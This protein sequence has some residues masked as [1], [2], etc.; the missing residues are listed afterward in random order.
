MAAFDQGITRSEILTELNKVLP[1]YNRVE[2]WPSRSGLFDPLL[3]AIEKAEGNI[4]LDGADKAVAYES[5]LGIEQSLGEILISFQDKLGRSF[6]LDFITALSQDQDISN[7]ANEFRDWVNTQITNK[8]GEYTFTGNATA[9]NIINQAIA[10]LNP[11][12]PVSLSQTALNARNEIENIISPTVNRNA[13]YALGIVGSLDS[14]YKGALKQYML[15]RD[16]SEVVTARN[17]FLSI[18]SN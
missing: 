5:Y 14:S 9:R 12:N 3:R 2:W 17:E 1:A 15:G 6:T 18:L 13:I 11:R 4:R 8:L 16:E 10:D 7:K